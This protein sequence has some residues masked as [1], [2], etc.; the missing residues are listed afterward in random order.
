MKV[1]CAHT[2]VVDIDSLIENP[3]NPNKH[4]QKQ[5][6]LLAKI[7]KHQGWRHAVTVSKR[8]GF[9]VAGHGRLAAARLNGWTQVPVDQQDFENE[10][11]E[12]AHL[13]ADNKIQELAESDDNMIQS[14]A[15]DIGPDFD[16]DLLGIEDFKI[17]GVD[18]LPPGSEDECPTAP[19]EA[20]SKRGQIWKL[21]NHR[22]M[23]GDSIDVKD[24]QFL[25]NGEKADMCFTSP[26][27]N[28]GKN[29]KL[30]GY[31]GDG[32]ETVYN[33]NTDHKTELE[34]FEFLKS[35]TS[36]AL[37]VSNTAFINIQLLAGN[38]FVIPEYWKFFKQNLVD[39]FCWDKEH[40]Q[41]SAAQRVLNSVWEF[42]FIFANE[43]NPTRSMKHGSDFRGTI[44][45][46]YRL[47][48]IGKKDP[49]AKD[50]G[51]VFPVQF[52]EFF[53]SNFSDE[54]I[55]EPF[56]G[57]GTTIIAC[58]KIGRKCYG[59]EIDPIYCDVIIKRWENYTGKKAEL[60]T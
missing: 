41:P 27:Y 32:K 36:I 1:N 26:P 17:K 42:I 23:C 18:T 34:Y 15:L 13:I 33:E 38:K 4:P 37:S 25:M 2:A 58:E 44:D 40:A 35:F 29:S 16:F 12:Y 57:S 47:N 55:Y 56:C 52:C 14:I 39:I 43:L 20:T 60:I 8:S 22:L 7:L 10:A 31:N 28:L 11:Q 49:L 48:P 50:H 24:V 9:V 54:K 21:G 3:R 59:M 53:I 46:I 51:A 45:N 5:I 30:R 19:L 6:E